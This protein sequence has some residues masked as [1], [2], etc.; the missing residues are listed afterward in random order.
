[1][2]IKRLM[3][4]FV[5][6][7]C[8]MAAFQMNATGIGVNDAKAVANSFLKSHSTCAP[9]T[10]RAPA[11]A[12]LRLAH[13]EASSK[14]PGTHLYY[15]FNAN[16]GGFIIVSGED[17]ATPVLGY[18]DKGQIDFNNLPEALK[19]LLD[20]YKEEI[21]YMQTHE[22]EVPKQ[23]NQSFNESSIVVAPLIKTYWGPEWPYYSQ[24]PVFDGAYSKVGCAGV[25]MAQ[26]L[27][28]WKFPRSCEALPAYF[29]SKVQDTIP[30]LPATTFEYKTMLLSYCYWDFD[31]Q[32]TV[33]D[34]YT[35]EQAYEVAKLCRYVGQMGQMNY[36]PNGSGLSLKGKLATM[37]KFG[38]NSSA[39]IAKRDSYTL[40]GWQELLK[41]ELNLE[42]PV[43]Y[44]AKGPGS[45]YHAF[46]C[47]G[48]TD[49]NYFHMNLGWYG[50]NNGWYKITAFSFINR[51]GSPRT[52]SLESRIL[53]GI[54]PPLYC[55]VEGDVDAPNRLLVLGETFNAMAHDVDLYTSYRTL[56][57][58]F[59]LTN[60]NGDCVAES[61]SLTVRRI[62][63]DFSN[64]VSLALTLPETLPEG[65]YDL[66]L[67]YRTSDNAALTTA[68]TANSRL[69]VVGKFAKYGEPFNIGDLT[70]AIDYL[71][72]HASQSEYFNIGDVSTLIDYLLSL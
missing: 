25:C 40:Q 54:E 12:D 32:S 57:F 43:M 58:M 36:S 17:L 5:L 69:T 41:R 11:A 37:K 15:A 50:Y 1:M 8:T 66:H 68:L 9:G 67:N 62:D 64:E 60:A 7:T 20:I 70:D 55:T 13:A 53:V 22:F 48:Y 6:A 59:T 3:C 14:V 29:G 35:D 30:A 23:L 51:Y 31:S 27:Y 28:F 2:I 10:F 24:C 52:Y 42:R 45:P 61:Q 71:L 4:L 63:F 19:D 21:E 56:P 49:D 18:S 46:I 72:Q 44:S 26:M 38:Y 16:G 65:T 47:D 39:V 34:N 33:Q